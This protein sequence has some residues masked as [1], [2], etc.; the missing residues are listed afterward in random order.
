MIWSPFRGRGRDRVEGLALSELTRE[1]VALDLETTGLDPRSDAIVA[2]AA[3]RFVDGEPVDGLVTLVNPERPIPAD[4]TRVHGIG[5]DAVSGAP[6]VGEVLPTLE[7]VCGGRVVVGHGLD[8]DLAV[9]DRAR[10]A[11]GL[12]ALRLT[13]L[14]TRRLA[15]VLH[16]DWSDYGLDAVAAR[17]GVP[18]EGRHTAEGD[19]IA[20][21]RILTALVPRLQARSIETVAEAAWLQRQVVF[22]R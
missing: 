14:D 6:S 20:A 9:I 18:V 17:L 3:I 21:G 1:F 19:A 12:P 22:E 13:T 8:F 4:A 7:R 15:A 10:R 11:A 2:A 16:R 5:D